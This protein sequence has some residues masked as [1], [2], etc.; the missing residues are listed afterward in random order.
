MPQ[1]T[2]IKSEKI[3]LKQLFNMWFQI[4]EYQRPYLWG[5][6]QVHD[7][8]DDLTFAM[9]NKPEAE[10]FLGS[11]VFQAKPIDKNV[12]RNFEESDLLDGQQLACLPRAQQFRGR[13][14]H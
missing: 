11:L 8:L 1:T 12:G 7:L 4:P 2:E 5:Y 9:E 6:D 14:R 13:V 3:L 10:Y